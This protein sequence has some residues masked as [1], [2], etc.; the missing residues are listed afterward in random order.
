MYVKNASE[1]IENGE[2]RSE[3]AARRL[4]LG[5]IEAALHAAEPGRLVKSKLRVVDGQLIV[6]GGT[7]NLSKFRRVL[8]IG[9]GKAAG[10]M[11]RAIELVLGNRITAGIVNVPALGPNVGRRKG[12]I[13][14]HPATH[15]LPSRSGQEGVREMLD[16]VGSPSKDDF[17]ICLISGGGSSL[18][19]MPSEG[20]SLTDK[21]EVTRSLLRAGATIQELNVVRKH[22]SA[23]K[24]GWLAKRLYP[25]VVLSLVISDVVGDRLDSIASGPLHP[26]SS[27]F[28]DA[29]QVLRKYGLWDGVPDGVAALLMRGVEGRAPETPKPGSRYFAKVINVIVGGNGDASSAALR[30]LKSKGQR[31]TLLTTSLEGEARFAGMFMGSVLQYASSRPRPSS[32]IVGGET[33]VTVRGD[34]RGGRNQE[35]ALGAAMKLDGNQGVAMVG[36]GT[37]G[38]DGTT[39]A[40]GAIVD[41]RTIGRGAALGLSSEETLRRNDTYRYFGKLGD[42][43]MTGP[44]GTNVNDVVVSV[45]A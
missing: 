37:D 14:L 33:T 26:D 44:T 43:V 8:V 30:Y 29:V 13:E 25:A 35:F 19:P 12:I 5:A 9:G 20:V 11:A 31:P 4:S 28:G 17:V 27:T 15:P 24:G 38:L 45:V 40:A 36:L 6:E 3:Q 18:L 41:G 21:M 1:L 16:L 42:L 10:P 39:N 22:L 23:L 2:T 32:F 7:Y 34:G